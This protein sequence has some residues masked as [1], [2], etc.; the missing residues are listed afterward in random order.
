MAKRKFLWKLP[1]RFNGREIILASYST[2][3]RG[4]RIVIL[5]GDQK[6]FDTGDCSGYRAAM[7]KIHAWIECQ[8][9]Q[10]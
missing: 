4:E 3:K 8:K 5:E 10:P 9:D 7:N 6:V 2:P 1:H